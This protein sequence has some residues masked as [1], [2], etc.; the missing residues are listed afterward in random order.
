MEVIEAGFGVV[1]VATVADGIQEGRAGGVDDDAAIRVC[2]IGQL[3]P[4]VV[5]AGRNL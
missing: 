3:A 1:V 4:G 2:Y 5:L